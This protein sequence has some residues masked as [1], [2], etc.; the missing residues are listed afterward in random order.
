M[1][2]QHGTGHQIRLAD[3]RDRTGGLDINPQSDSRLLHKGVKNIEWK[4]REPLE[5][6]VLGKLYPS[7]EG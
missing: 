4:K 6:M 3:Q 5:Q 2:Q 1:T 7:V